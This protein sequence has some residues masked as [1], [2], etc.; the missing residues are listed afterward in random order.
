MTQYR[1][2]V[3]L[4]LILIFLPVF[5]SAQTCVDS[6]FNLGKIDSGWL[7]RNNNTGI[8]FQLPQ[9][10]F[11]FDQIASER[12]YIRIG[13][14]YAKLSAPL[15][16]NSPGAIIAL[17]QIQSQPLDFA[18]TLF[19]I[20]KL[21]DTVA[22]VPMANEI[23]S[24]KSISCKAYY[25]DIKEADTLLKVLFQKYTRSKELPE[26]KEGKLGELPYKYFILAVANK[27]GKLE[28]RIYGVRNFGCFNII[29]RLTY[30]TDADLSLMNDACKDLK[31]QQ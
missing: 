15:V 22:L 2:V 26:I 29:I 30:I 13:S 7:Y 12:K 5:V 20:A 8:S 19:S 16:D 3:H 23:Q 24:N 17:N 4:L 18:L 9:G 10:W 14:D 21:D 28:H 1:F 31:F 11:F 25:A 27:T 6:S